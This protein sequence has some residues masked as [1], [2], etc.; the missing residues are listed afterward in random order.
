[1]V[2]PLQ[3]GAR[4]ESMMAPSVALGSG[5]PVLAIGSAGGTRLRTA[6]VTVASSILD[7]GVEP[8]AAVDRPRAHRAANV[9]NAEPGVYEAAL[10]ELET[11]G[12][13]VKRW[14]SRHHYF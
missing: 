8:Q 4:M 5:G 2:A 6:L 13:T 11:R 1:V 3:P 7:E 14:P 12:L 10:V 9:V